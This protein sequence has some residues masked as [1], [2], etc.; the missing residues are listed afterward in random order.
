[1]CVNKIKIKLIK[2]MS[3]LYHPK[4]TCTFG[5]VLSLILDPLRILLFDKGLASLVTGVI[6]TSHFQPH[7][8]FH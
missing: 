3:C 2:L 8:L 1:M 4:Y 5:H 7:F 6:Y